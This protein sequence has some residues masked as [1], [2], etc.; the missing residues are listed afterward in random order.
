VNSIQNRDTTDYSMNFG[1]SP[2][3]HLGT[4]VLTFNAGI[5]GTIRRDSI[6]PVALNQNLFRV[7]TY[8]TTSSFFDAVSVSGFFIRESGPFTESNLHSRS[9]VGG[10][11]FRVGQPWG[12]TA[13][14]TGWAASDQQFQPENIVNFYTSSYVG[15]ERRFS[16]RWN[17]RAVV[18]DLRTWR[19]VQTRYGIA[20]ALVP[21]GT[22]GFRPARNWRIQ[23]SMAYS[24]TRGF[25]DYDA[26]QNGFSVSYAM[27]F[28]RVFKGEGEEV[29]L[30]Y[31]IRFSAGM[32]QE[33]FFNF[34][35]A[36]TQQFR[37]Y[38]SISLF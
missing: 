12:K 22:V 20:Q 25:H 3:V 24:N 37:P 18:E 7:Y 9:L 10:V 23:A 6:S 35:G 38:F 13:L 11:D 36:N 27:P 15:L 2:S 19:I 5:Q 4:N 32:Q 33:S 1:L 31:P 17:V 8:M 16:D 26:V 30:Q 21:A 28:R 29:P 34:P 14:V